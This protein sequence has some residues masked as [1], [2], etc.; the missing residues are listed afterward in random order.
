MPIRTIAGI[1]IGLAL[2]VAIGLAF[3]P[4][5]VPADIVT[6]GRGALAV[7]VDEEGQTRVRDIY[8]VSAPVGGRVLRIRADVGDPVTQGETVVATIQ[9]TDPSFLDARSL[10]QAEAQVKAAEAA[11][12]LAAADVERARAELDFAQSEYRRAQ[13]LAAKGNVSQSTLDKARLDMRTRAAA[14][15]EAQAALSMRDFELENARALLIQPGEGGE[16]GEGSVAGIGRTSGCCVPVRSPITGRVLRI[17][18]ESESIVLPGAPLI[19]VGNADDLEI[20]VDLLSED[21]VRVTEGD[22]VAIEDWGGPEVLNG[23][24]RRVEPFGFTKVSALGIEEQRVNVIIEFE[25][26]AEMWA[27]LGHGYRLD[28]R[29]FV[30]EADDVLTVPVSAL[31]RNAGKWAVFRDDD[32]EAVLT[33]IEIGRRNALE[34]AVESG[35]EEGDRVVIHP[36]DRVVDGVSLEP[37]GLR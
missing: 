6:I 4:Q 15:D 29:I 26:P 28:T 5:P 13:R 3:M 27:E 16:A 30:W 14:I 8:T 12:T 9:P 10:G 25:D 1:G 22:R 21:A 11:R 23:I 19:E 31:F 24:V 18:Q 36:S 33:A 32:G 2:L 35:L 37:R 34:A 7:T 20:V 17:M